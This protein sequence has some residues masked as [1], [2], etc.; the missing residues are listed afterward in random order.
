VTLSDDL[1][2]M[3]ITTGHISKLEGIDDYAT[4][5]RSRLETAIEKAVI[6]MGS[7]YALIAPTVTQAL[8]IHAEGNEPENEDAADILT[9][10]LAAADMGVAWGKLT[11]KKAA[12]LKV[13]VNS[14]L[15][16]KSN[17]GTER[18]DVTNDLMLDIEL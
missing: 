3:S 8:I 10:L 6:A 9:T 16:D 17:Y 14:L 2:K 12:D 15:Q 11:E 1:S 18:E 7:A 13:M 5:A 4:Y